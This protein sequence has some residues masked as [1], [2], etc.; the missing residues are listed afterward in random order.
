[1]QVGGW[2]PLVDGMKLENA[3]VFASD[4]SI[5]A[6]VKA[7]LDFEKA[8][9]EPFPKPERIKLKITDISGTYLCIVQHQGSKVCC[10]ALD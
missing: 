6:A 5:P 1:M 4:D 8:L 2:E 3:W 10:T 7:F 9:L